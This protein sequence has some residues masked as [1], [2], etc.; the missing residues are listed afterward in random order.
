M[1]R[2]NTVCAISFSAACTVLHPIEDHVFWVSFG[3]IPLTM[4]HSSFSDQ[5]PLFYSCNP[6]PDEIAKVAEEPLSDKSSKDASVS[7]LP[8]R[9]CEGTERLDF[10]V[11]V[12]VQQTGQPS[13]E[14]LMNIDEEMMHMMVSAMTKLLCIMLV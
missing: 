14:N 10:A 13:S 4:A 12:A 1:K 2:H 5:M 6:D 11:P 8:S 9:L 3:V 7:S